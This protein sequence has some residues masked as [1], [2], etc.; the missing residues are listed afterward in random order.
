MRKNLAKILLFTMAIGAFWSCQ[1]QP[2]TV[3]FPENEIIGRYQ[4]VGWEPGSDFQTA[5]DYQ[6]QATILK[7][8]ELYIFSS[9]I[10]GTPFSGNGIFDEASQSIAFIF[11][12]EDGSRGVSFFRRPALEIGEEPSKN[13]D[14]RWAYS[15]EGHSFM[16]GREIWQ[17]LDIQ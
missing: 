5:G 17:K 1:K 9:V 3:T 14:V 6:G 10:D 8:G 4:I 2:E 16:C 15:G 13:W 7:K 11:E 12:G